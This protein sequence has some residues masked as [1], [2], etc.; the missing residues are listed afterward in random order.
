MKNLCKKWLL[1]WA[2]PGKQASVFCAR[3]YGLII[4]F[5]VLTFAYG[6]EQSMQ[7]TGFIYADV[8]FHAVT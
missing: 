5:L 7:I 4:P 8:R 3:Y 6:Y 2:G 1:T